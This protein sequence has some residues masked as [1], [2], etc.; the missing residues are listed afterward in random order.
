MNDTHFDHKLSLD[1]L[2]ALLLRAK[3]DTKNG[4]RNYLMILIGVCHGLRNMEICGL[5]AATFDME[6][7]TLT[8]RRGKKSLK[9][10]QPLMRSDDPLLDEYSAV[11]AY[12]LDKNGI[13]KRGRLFDIETGMLRHLFKRYAKDAGIPKA[14]RHPHVLKHTAAHYALDSS[15]RDLVYV[16]KFLGHKNLSSTGMYL[17]VSDTEACAAIQPNYFK[18]S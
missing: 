4:E 9:T 14:L 13:P 8:V 10:T 7:G 18:K 3:S 5:T 6:D 12:L 16:Q 17:K 1:Q 11:K 2:K 15:K